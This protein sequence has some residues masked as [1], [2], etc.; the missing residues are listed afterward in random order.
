MRVTCRQFPSYEVD[1]AGKVYRRTSA[2]GTRVGRR[3]RPSA[4]RCGEL[5][6]GLMLDG[7]MRRALVRDLVALAFCGDP[8]TPRHRAARLDRDRSN[9]R[10]ENLCWV[11]SR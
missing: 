5:T 6:V 1:R 9:N 8:P 11:V 7:R 4:N 10:P 2:R 3:L